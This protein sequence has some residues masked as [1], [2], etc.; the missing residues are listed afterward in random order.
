MGVPQH[1]HVVVRVRSF[2]CRD[3]DMLSDAQSIFVDGEHLEPNPPKDARRRISEAHAAAP[4][5]D[6]IALRAHTLA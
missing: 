6:A 3:E 5:R 2:P 4:R 1:V